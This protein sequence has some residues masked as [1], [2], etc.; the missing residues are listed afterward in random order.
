MTEIPN[1]KPDYDLEE[2]S[3]QFAKPA[4]LFVKKL[5]QTN[6]IIEDDK[7]LFWSLNIVI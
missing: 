4:E 7:Q 1:S 3:L 6:A 5:P 2:R